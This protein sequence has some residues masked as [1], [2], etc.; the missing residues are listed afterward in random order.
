MLQVHKTRGTER[1]LVEP[2]VE[3]LTQIQIA[4]NIKGAVGLLF[5][6]AQGY[7]ESNPAIELIP[8]TQAAVSRYGGHLFSRTG[9]FASP[10]F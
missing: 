10:D 2:F 7:T 4:A 3:I 6:P 5:R 1:I 9:A 8:L